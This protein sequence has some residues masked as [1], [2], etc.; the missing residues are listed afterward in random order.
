LVRA[1]SERVDFANSK[2][3]M[4]DRIECGI[5]INLAGREPNGVVSED[6]YEPLREAL[7]EELRDLTAP[8]GTP[9]FS[10]VGPREEYFEGPYLDDAVDVLTVPRD[11]DVMLSAQL[12]D[13]P[14]AATP[15]EPWNHKLDGI[16]AL[17]GA[18]VDASASLADA[19]LY[20]VASTVLS[21]LGVA[22]PETMAGRPLAPVDDAGS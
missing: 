1:A 8:D 9:V 13:E 21:T 4:R 19:H 11:F 10:E 2:A 16:V 17:S 14:F 5:R 18:G 6:E 7:V 12:H 15:M 3:Y 20:D 22:Y